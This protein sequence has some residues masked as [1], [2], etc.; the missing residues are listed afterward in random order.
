[1]FRLF[2]K[3]LSIAFFCAICLPV[4]LPIFA[5]ETETKPL[6]IPFTNS[7]PFMYLDADGNRTG[8][9]VELSELLAAELN[10]S[11]QYR[12]FDSI[13][14]AVGAQMRGQTDMIAGI[15]ALPFFEAENLF[16][17]PVA[18][19]RIRIT[20]RRDRETEFDAES[21]TGKRIAIVGQSIDPAT[22]R[23]LVQNQMVPYGSAEA[24][25]MGLMTKHV[26]AFVFPEPIVYEISRTA[27]LDGRIKFVGEP[28]R[29]TDRVVALNKNRADLLNAINKAIAKL[30]HDGT[31][32]DL[33][34]RYK[35]T[36]PPPP[37]EVLTVG[38][39]HDPPNAIVGKG[40]SF[41]GFNVEVMRDLAERSGLKITFKEVSNDIWH[42]GPTASTTDMNLGLVATPQ[43]AENMYFTS[44]IRE[45]TASLL[46]TPE[47]AEQIPAPQNLSGLKIGVTANP[48]L[49]D[50]AK[51]AGAISF[52]EF[53]SHEAMLAALLEG[54]IDGFI[55]PTQIG[56][57]FISD[58]N[59]DDAVTVLSPPIQP[60]DIAIAQ[61]FGLG[62]V[63]DKL[64]TI[65]PPYLLSERYSALTKKYYG[66]PEFWTTNRIFAAQI[67]AVALV[68]ALIS[69][70]FF[71]VA[72]ARRARRVEALLRSELETIFNAASSGIIALDEKGTIIRIN[73]QARHMLGGIS[74]PTPF[75]WPEK[76]SFL[77]AETMAPLEE[78]ADPI[79]RALSGHNLN[80]ET[81]LLR[82]VQS[83]EQR[84]YVRVD[85]A[86]VDRSDTGIA[87]V[88]VIDDVSNEERNRQVVE[89]KSRLDALGQLTGGIAHDFNN[90][91]ASLL[92]AID[93]GR[94]APTKAKRDSFLDIAENSIQRGRALTSRLLSFARRQP[95]LA[96]VRRASLI[97]EDFEK[98]VRPMM[99]AHIE[100]AVKTDDP[101][102]RIFCDQAQLE[103]AL[104]NLVLNS[105]DAILRSGK[106]SRIELRTRAVLAPNK[107]LDANQKG[108][109]PT[110]N[111]DS[112]YRYVEI[113][114]SDNGP[115]M[116]EETLA[117][118]TDPFFTTK[119][120]NSGTGLGL[121]MV[122]GFIRQS[123]GDLRIYSEEG[124]GTTIQLTLPR[125]TAHGDREERVENKIPTQGGGE[126][127]LIVE[128]EIQLLDMMVELLDDLGY[129]T[130][131]ASS[132]KDAAK[133]LD[134]GRHFDLLLT[135]VVMPGKIGGFALA[136]MMREKRPELPVI[137]IS[138]Y[139]GYTA[140]EMGEVQAPLLQKPAPAKELS[141]AIQHA[142]QAG[143]ASA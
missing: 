57:T 60:I 66:K 75:E 72:N 109:K 65:I 102:L 99:E 17:A 18:Q 27:S 16:S 4:S 43:L 29:I 12:P 140:N 92:Y 88:L 3:F 49:I 79:R 116:D 2:T 87:V 131:A 11:I 41:S 77:E 25:I 7:P 59:A 48:F 101:E 58:Q 20:I 119:D 13:Q 71:V 53:T 31:L 114:V 122:Y 94:K 86:M 6:T 42:Q 45:F 142:L 34:A 103:T 141:D 115:G 132:G 39:R 85:N 112:A 139:T 96:T 82:R 21:I 91:L 67:A 108:K 83:G 28:L 35:I 61:R 50:A 52:A 129:K 93:L 5:Q 134:Q 26:D 133:L 124:I 121:A 56:H 8:F 117:R 136:R 1:M 32:E 111:K 130:I 98:L 51:K 107:E 33:R 10:T 24:A 9:F 135:D 15:A 138:G 74:D 46:T 95:G 118:S 76:I 104:M 38:V 36:V 63:R 44:P 54:Q 110:A 78:S 143:K 69:I 64:N 89:R 22:Q 80:S 90:L 81:H 14:E 106:G 113:S 37:S 127:I 126:T 105:R 55:L 73:K 23:L 100:I 125:G 68:L 47:K 97:L 40:G 84:R 19:D 70:G 128:D 137:Y 62:S 123:D 120:S 30:E